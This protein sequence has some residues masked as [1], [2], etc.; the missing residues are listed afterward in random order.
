[1]KFM[2]VAFVQ[3]G[4]ATE[5]SA[6]YEG[7]VG[8][9]TSSIQGNR[10][11][12]TREGSTAP[13]YSTDEQSVLSNNPSMSN[14]QKEAR[15]V[16]RGHAMRWSTDDESTHAA[17]RHDQPRQLDERPPRFRHLRRCPNRRNALRCER[18]LHGAAKASWTFRGTGSVETTGPHKYEYTPGSGAMVIVPSTWDPITDGSEAPLTH[19]N[20]TLFTDALRTDTWAL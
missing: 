16:R 7:I 3:I 19:G 5:F 1:M 11:L 2:Q 9:F 17:R 10:Y 18:C 6:T 12:D 13:Y 8:T 15:T 14:P 4:K 20:Q